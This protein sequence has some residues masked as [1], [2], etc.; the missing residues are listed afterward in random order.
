MARI[1]LNKS[2]TLA[3]GAAPKVRVKFEDNI[4]FVRP[5]DRTKGM[6]NLPKGEVV[7]DLKDKSETAKSFTVS[8]EAVMN[9]TMYVLK[10]AKYGWYALVATP[11]LEARAT[12]LTARVG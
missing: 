3:F 1:V 9:G 2:A 6:A 4:M 11:V 8:H 7:I 10:A 5:T 12:D